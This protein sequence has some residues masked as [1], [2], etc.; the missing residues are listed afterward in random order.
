MSVKTVSTYRARVLE[1]MNLKTNG[2]L[3][4][5]VTLHF[6]PYG[7][8]NL[9]PEQIFANA[10]LFGHNIVKVQGAIHDI[11]KRDLPLMITEIN[12]SYVGGGTTKVNPGGL[13][14]GLWLADVI[15][16]AAQNGLAAIIPWT[17][18]R[19]GGLSILD[20]SGNPRPTY[21]AIHAFSGMGATVEALA[22]LPVGLIGYRSQVD[23]GEAFEVL[24]NLTAQSI[25][26]PIDDK[27]I[28]LGEYSLTRLHFDI[29]GKLVDGAVYGQKEFEAQQP[30]ADILK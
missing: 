28:K 12:L 14:A 9:T 29:S 20:D 21:Y 27:S 15:G 18:T 16:K 5:V 25:S 10:D 26:L 7:S 19:N 11:V 24:I 17:A 22:G 2:D 13:F 4:D 1:K 8:E 30:P 23:V 6:Y 3:I